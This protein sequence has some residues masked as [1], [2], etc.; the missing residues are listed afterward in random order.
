MKPFFMPA[1][2]AFSALLV[3]AGCDSVAPDAGGG[4]EEFFTRVVLTLQGD[5]GSTTTAT[6]RDADGDR[7]N[8]EFTPLVLASGVTYTGALTLFDDINEEDVTGEIA[9]ESAAHLFFFTPVGN[10]APRIT[11]TRL[12]ADANGAPL[13][14]AFRVEVSAGGAATGSLDVRL[15]HYENEADKRADHTPENRSGSELELDLTFPV[16]IR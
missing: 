11:V 4:E 16:A 2:L 13:G 14:L 5:D 3:V 7:A 8:I 6:A 15:A 10:A 1:L 12:D 9:E